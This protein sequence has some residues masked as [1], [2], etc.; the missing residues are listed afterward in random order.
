MRDPESPGNARRTDPRHECGGSNARSVVS[1]RSLLYGTHRCFVCVIFFARSAPEV[2]EIVSPRNELRIRPGE[3]SVDLDDRE[4]PE[5]E[6]EREKERERE[7]EGGREKGQR[8]GRLR[9]LFIGYRVGNIAAY[10]AV[11]D[12]LPIKVMKF[13]CDISSKW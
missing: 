5:R 4:E 9:R 11:K 2:A 12:L 8:R 10:V 6:R 13:E 1:C 7:R 3:R